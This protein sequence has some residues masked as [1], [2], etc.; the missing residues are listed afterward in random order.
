MKKIQEINK[1]E[2]PE[3]IKKLN[4]N[5]SKKLQKCIEDLDEAVSEEK[6][7]DE[8]AEEREGE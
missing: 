6:E 8:E 2:L 3:E 4:G 7:H 5:S 1:E